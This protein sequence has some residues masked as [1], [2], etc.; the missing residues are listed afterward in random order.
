MVDNDIDK[1][2]DVAIGSN[3]RFRSRARSVA[4]LTAAAAA[5]LAAGLVLVPT[6]P[7]PLPARIAGLVSIILLIAATGLF[8]AAGVTY[9]TRS[10]NVRRVKL[11]DKI[12]VWRLLV[13]EPAAAEA[14][15]SKMRLDQAVA[16]G[17]RIR[18]IIDWGLCVGIAAM[19][20]LVAAL[21][22]ITLYDLESVKVSI[23]IQDA[24]RY[25]GCPDLTEEFSGS[26]AGS[27]LE[28]DSS[29]VRI[30]VAP[31]ECGSRYPT[32]LFLP[33][34]EISIAQSGRS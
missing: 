11:L 21:A 27:I 23:V 3:E 20:A 29:H 28:G 31:S 32:T 4:T 18:R 34:G 9:A 1:R 12:A 8:V 5:A 17:G 22:M 19:I 15:N 10:K 16:V 6:V 14:L 25:P 24:S 13:E 33:R 30:V 2:V 7:S 26:V